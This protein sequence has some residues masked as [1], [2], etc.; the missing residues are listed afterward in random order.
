[1]KRNSGWLFDLYEHPTK[2]IVLWIV[3][4]DGKSYSFHQDFEIVFYARGPAERL[5][6]LGVF[7][8]TKYSRDDV[9]LERVTSKEDLFDGPQ[10]VMSIGVSNLVLCKKMLREVNE[11]FSDLIL[12]DVDIPLTVRYAAAHNVFM[13]A[14]C[15]VETEPDGKIVSIQTLDSTE[16]LDPKLPNLKILSMHPDSNPFDTS[17]KYLVLKYGKSYLRLPFDKPHELLSILNSVLS[18]F[19]PDVIHTHFGDGS[20]FSYLMEL[21]KKTGVPF[22]PNRDISVPVVQRK[23]VTFF[24]YGSA[25]Y[26]ASQIHLRGR[27]HVDVEN[28]MNYN[29]YHLAGAIEQTRL[30]SLPLQEVARRSPG[31]AMSAMQV[32]T[33]LRRNTL[34]PYQRQKAE[35]PKTFNEYFKAAR[36]GLIL[37]PPIGVFENVAVLDFSSK[38]ASIMIKYNASPETVVSIE[39]EREG[40]EIPE[41]KVKILSRPGLMQ[42][43]LRPMRDKR[44][45]LK[46]ILKSMD[47]SDPRY[48]AMQNRYKVVANA[49]SKKAV[50]D[51]IK[52][53]IVVCYGRLGF[54]NAVFGRRNAH[55]VV[56]YLSRKMITKANL[57]AEAMGFR[58]LHL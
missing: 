44:L 23:E 13:M 38:M 27:W 41:L 46:R 58:V 21:S 10:E 28:C 30:S 35:I 16:E 51:A 9:K 45:A 24:N 20:L 50:S 42:E 12:Y 5:H 3:G 40:F 2:G 15:E 52:W 22:N 56:S 33:A 37:Q 29:K 1:M 8:R 57:I 18:S 36:G 7:I 26:R 54:A 32:L 53:L 47:K 4:E 25:H 55:Q 39:D 43:T 17:P 14:Y 34:I 31:A 48:R 6:D 19:D 11:N 49:L